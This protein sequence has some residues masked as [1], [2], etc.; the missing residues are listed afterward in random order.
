MAHRLLVRGA[1][2]LLTLRGANPWDLGLIGNGALLV[3]DGLIAAVGPARQVER[4]ARGA[5]LLDAR[6][7]VVMPGFVDSHTHLVHGPPRLEGGGILWTAR[8][9]RASSSARLRMMAQ[10]WLSQMLAHGTTTVE[11]K[12]GYGLNE[13][14]EL[15]SL[16]VSAAL[17]AIP[18][19]LGA[20]VTP[21]EF[22]GRPDAYIDWLIAELMPVIARRRLARFADVYCDSGA[23][24]V[25]QARRYLL[26]ARSL[27]LGLRIHASQF[28]N[29]GAVQLAVEL[30]VMSADHL[31]AIGEAELRALAESRV[32]ATLLPG[33][34][35]HLGLT[36]YAPARALIDAGVT[37]ALATDFNPGTSPTPSMP[38]VLS[39][40]C[41]QMRMTPAE[42]IIAATLHGAHALGLAAR[43]G[44]LEVGKRADLAV[45]SVSDY[46]EAPYYF[47]VNPLAATVR[48]GAVHIN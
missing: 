34:V 27:G 10:K 24:T 25:E 13:A 48:Q 22:E 35:Y 18:T 8:Q 43:T 14:A 38:M 1:R 7:G 19:F 45:L 28:A 2:Q 3:E 40:A 5:E 12:S 42:A 20:H 33:S 46:R 15:R 26:A 44:S 47:G 6:G 23:F 39:L 4:L 32:V 37:V 30:G 31:E 29:F 21:P 41:T 9:V 11:A 17:G 36:R 16:R